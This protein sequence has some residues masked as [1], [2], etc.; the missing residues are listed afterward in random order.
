MPASSNFP[1]FLLINKMDREN[2]N[3]QKALKSVEEYSEITLIPVQIPWGEK[4]GFQGVIDLL[5][6]KA[7][8]GD[9]K[10]A[11]EIPAE[12]KSAAEEGRT[13]LVEAAAEGDD[14]LM[15][16]ISIPAH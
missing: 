8:K 7:Y 4:Q 10:T 6:M 15:E 2:A 9:G 16:S 5:T 13:K 12:Y 3:Y 14:A 1:A 11:V